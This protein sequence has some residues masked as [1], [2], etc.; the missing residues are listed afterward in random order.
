ML[1]RTLG[2]EQ[3]ADREAHA[4]R[5][6]EGEA[7]T[8]PH[9]PARSRHERRNAFLF[10]WN[11]GMGDVAL[12]LV[13]LFARIRREAPGARIAVITREELKEPFELTGIDEV[14]VIPGLQR[15]ARIDL[16]RACAALGIDFDAFGTVFD[17]PDPNR[18]LEGRRH[19]FPPTLSWNPQWDVHAERLLPV[20]RNQIVIA[21]RLSTVVHCDRIIVLEQGRIVEQGTHAE[22][23]ARAGTYA[24][25]AQ[26]QFRESAA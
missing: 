2:L 3:R 14:H 15:E 19:E 4:E 10:Y 16:S 5:D 26:R 17:Y 24:R 20:P 8:H 18:W 13:P 11:R 25:L 9:R 23:L 22:L 12:C 21:H 1:R 7:E 6:E